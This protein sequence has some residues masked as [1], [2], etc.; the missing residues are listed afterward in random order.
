MKRLPR[1]LLLAGFVLLIFG[2][3]LWLIDYA[4]TE[5]PVM[6]QWDAE[7]K[8]T[9]RPWVDGQLGL[10]ELFHPH[11][12]HR[13][14]VGKLYAL[15]LLAANGEWDAQLETVANA[16]VHTFCALVLLL[17]ARRWL[18]GGALTVF[19]ALLVLLF[20]LPFSWE[21]TLGGFQVAFYFLLLFSIGHI[22]LSL[23]SDGF[24]ARWVVGQLCGLLAIG[25]LASGFFSAAMILGVLGV[26][27][28]QTR[29]WTTQQ[30]V[31]AAI[32][33]ALCIA[34]WSMRHHVPGHDR[35]MAQNAGQFFGS[36]LAL[37]AWPG[38][39][40]MP[41]ALV[42]WTPAAVWLVRVARR[43][44]LSASD[45]VLLGLLGWVVLQCA[46]TAYSRGGGIALSS[47]YLDLAALNVALGFIFIARELSGRWRIATGAI[48]LL[49]TLGGLTQQ[50]ELHWRG[51]IVPLVRHRESQEA[52]VRAYLATGNHDI[53]LNKRWPDIVYPDPNYLFHVLAEPEIRGIMPPVVRPPVPLS[54]TAAPGRQLPPDLP[55]PG[56]P[57]AVSTWAAPNGSRFVWRSEPADAAAPPVLRFLVAGDLG[58]PGTKLRLVVKSDTG[59]SLV[60]PEVAP[61]HRWK[62]VNVFRPSGAWWIEAEDADPHAWFAATEPVAVGRWSWLVGKLLKHRLV[63]LFVG[64]GAVIAGALWWL[65]ANFRSW[66]KPPKDGGAGFSAAAVLLSGIAVAGLLANRLGALGA[67][68]APAAP[69]FVNAA[70]PGEFAPFAGAV[71]GPQHGRRFWLG[72]YAPGDAFK[73]DVTTPA[74]ELRSPQLQIPVV[75]YPVTGGNALD[76]QILDRDNRVIATITYDGVAPRETPAYWTVGVEA[77]AGQRARFVLHDRSATA[78]GW[79]GIGVVKSTSSPG[80]P[81]LIGVPRNYAWFALAALAV[82]GL[83]FIPGLALRTWRPR[84][85]TDCA[86][87]VAVPGLLLLAGFGVFVWAARTPATRFVALA[88]LLLVALAAVG[89]AI[90]WWRRGVPWAQPAGSSLVIYTSLALGA[91]A[92]GVLP[93]T[94]EQEYLARSSA[95]GRM[96][97]SPPD[98][99]IPYRSA[100]Y[101]FHHKDGRENRAVYF[102]QDWSAAS[103]GPL[104]AL[105]ITACFTLFGETPADPPGASLEAWPAPPD[106]FYLA[107][108]V[109]IL[110]N[111][112]VV[113]GGAALAAALGG[114]PAR[115][116][117]LCWLAVAPVVIINTDFVWPKLLATFFVCLAARDAFAGRPPW[118][119]GAWTAL[120]YLSH[121]VGGLF[122]PVLVIAAAWNR[123]A[124]R[125]P[126]LVAH[127]RA[128]I[129]PAIAYVATLLACVLPWFAFKAWVAFPDHMLRYPLGDGR[130]FAPAAS[131]GSWLIC[132]LK[133]IWFTLAPGAYYFAGFLRQW[134]AGPVSEPGR[135]AVGYAK[136]LPGELGI[137]MFLAAAVVVLRR[138]PNETVRTFRGLMLAGTGLI[139]LVFWGYSS[140][141]LGRNCL[142][143]L[144]VL[145]IAYVAAARPA[146]WQF[147]SGLLVVAA[148]EAFSLRVIG[149]WAD[150]GFPAS[151]LDPEA[152]FLLGLTALGVL[153]PAGFYL[154]HG[155]GRGES[156]GLGLPPVPAFPSS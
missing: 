132:R 110:T 151:Q 119:P 124:P 91:L 140:D 19:A 100:V 33:F 18:R 147:L 105:A 153:A 85:V 44:P 114:A 57:V 99:T 87:T 51:G 24:G 135:W 4:G 88:W 5:V 14:V 31:T 61:G 32:A 59:E 54:S 49:G 146:R 155:P 97:A 77:W 127:A 9:F 1:W 15:G 26:R 53:L 104:A 10:A 6:D 125:G 93:L 12:E 75:G 41:W 118:R 89:L 152:P 72:T 27:L 52:T 23:E 148:L 11:N 2:A 98:H 115:R 103:R 7:G 39:G 117:A 111:A 145:L 79:L 21:N 60:I 68:R 28:L 55:A 64:A 63:F 38:S 149:V 84:G 138:P 81:W 45:A 134:I 69:E 74:F 83:L 86:A 101:F 143:P 76:L 42:L 56:Y 126:G 90:H 78:G 25:S 20:S 47:R 136:T 29:R 144:A 123:A 34:G 58:A 109:G 62:S 17:L 120:A 35:L 113:L 131:L 133:N 73:G 129:R 142:E 70:H 8:M 82:A 65:G 67:L 66:W 37:L 43:R 141:G 46:A 40:F 96:V 3:K 16:V 108:I 107:R 50:T 94:V 128:A 122:A 71:A 80:V 112:L 36:L 116:F 30:I 137:P 102:G 22:V 130:G 121:P 95:Q 92:F 139:M 150:G 13:V 156:P 106:G 48:W 154:A